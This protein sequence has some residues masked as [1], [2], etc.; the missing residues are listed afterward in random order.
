MQAQV[1]ESY[2]ELLAHARLLTV[3]LNPSEEKVREWERRGA[4]AA[5]SNI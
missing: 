3:D 5:W 2:T 4:A 1:Q